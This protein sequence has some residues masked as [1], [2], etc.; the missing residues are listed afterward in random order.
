MNVFEIIEEYWDEEYFSEIDEQLVCICERDFG[1]GNRVG[2]C[3]KKENDIYNVVLRYDTESISKSYQKLPTKK[4]LMK[5]F[6]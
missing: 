1:D 3:V 5:D 4:E 2:I 6:I